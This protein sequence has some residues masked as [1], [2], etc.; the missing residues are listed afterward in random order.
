MLGA[1]AQYVL[2]FV[3]WISALATLVIF[4]E[5]WLALTRRNQLGARRSSG[6]EG[7]ISALV[8]LRGCAEDIRITV[9]SILDQSYP[10]I[11]LLLIY[12]E[13]DER[14]ARVAGDFV[15]IRS[16]IPVR[17]VPVPFALDA[18]TDRIRALDH[19]HASVRGSWLLVLESDVV[20]DRHALES[21]LEFATS[22]DI[23][24]VAL[25]PGIECRSLAQKL[26]APSLEWFVRMIRV[27][28]RGREK[29]Q[30]MNLVEP[31][32]LLH[33]HTHTVINKMNRLPGILN[34]AGWTLWSYRSEGLRTFQGDGSGWISREATARSLMS[35]VD[36]E[37]LSVGRVS[38]FVVGSAVVSIVSVIGIV[39][40]LFSPSTSVAG[41]GILYFAASS[42]GLMA[43]SYFC[44]SRRLGAATW[45]A[46]F[47][48]FAHSFALVLMLIELRRGRTI[49]SG[50]EIPA[51][52]KPGVPTNTD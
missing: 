3:C 22:E 24:A 36:T 19:A 16:H 12:D 50:I 5:S 15:S 21:A 6:T 40:G 37:V 49:G 41:M 51:S 13:R 33:G 20:L 23:T 9:G 47:W 8:P 31:F 25:S 7:V 34:E 27:V 26:L 35:N 4:L 38:A 11:E 43:I 1:L 2:L 44:Y 30:R 29:S 52:S 45:F 10:F 28:D 42:Y 14:H 46:P 48:F 32:L 18:E 39:F 17:A